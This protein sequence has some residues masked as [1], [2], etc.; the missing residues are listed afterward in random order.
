MKLKLVMSDAETGAV[1]QE[2]TD[3][4][5]AMMCFAKEDEEGLNYESRIATDRI[6][7]YGY[8]KC[9]EQV[10]SSAT[11]AVKEAPQI[12]QDIALK[13]GKARLME[14]ANE[15]VKDATDGWLDDAAEKK[16]EAA[17]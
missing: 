11:K 2:A 7:A 4:T 12:V 5:F 14:L 1:L 17:E 15:V 6:S 3:L 8:A 9:L 10:H 16:E 13:L